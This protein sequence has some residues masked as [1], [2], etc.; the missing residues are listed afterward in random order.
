MKASLPF[1][2]LERLEALRK[3]Q[4][5]DTADELVYDDLV[6]LAASICSTPLAAISLLDESRMWFKARR[7]LDFREADRDLSFCAHAIL[8]P[9]QVLVVPDATTDPRFSD[10][11]LVRGRTQFRFYSGAPLLNPEGLP[12][13]TLCVIDTRARPIT[14]AQVEA[15]RALSRQ[16]VAQLELRRT[17][18]VLRGQ[19][20]ELM[21]AREDAKAASKA[22]STFLANI[23]HE[24]R[25]PMNGV[26]GVTSL[27]SATPLSE[28]QRHYVNTIERSAEGLLNV[29]S[30]ILDFS[31]NET[32]SVAP[33][34]VPI[35]LP[36]FIEEIADM[37]RPMAIT[38]QLRFLAGVD[39]EIR[40]PLV[41]DPIRLHQVLA[42]L[43]GNA[44]KFTLQGSVEINV[45]LAGEGPNSQ[46]AR[47]QVRDTGIGVSKEQQSA[48]FDEFVQ[49][50]EGTQRRF[51]GAGLGLSICRQL[52]K[53][54]GTKIELKSEIGI[55]STFWFDLEMPFEIVEAP[56]VQSAAAPVEEARN[57]KPRVL[58][59]EDNE[60][61]SLVITSMLEHNGCDVVCVSDGDE[62]VSAVAAQTF[63][64]VFMDVQ[65]PRMDGVEATK[66]IRAMT[67]SCRSV[68]IIALTASVLRED[69][70]MCQMAGMDDFMSKPISERSIS[71]ALK[72]WIV[73]ADS[74]LWN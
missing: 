37:M 2:E 66:V 3:Y 34:L 45:S 40:R 12:L 70:I 17:K 63:D 8:R 56:S 51:G 15:L 18:L 59:A 61:N 22:K 21:R 32:S 1:N 24:I 69:A 10:N 46:V 36:A 71:E 30:N 26:V 43:V 55:G 72:R 41:G 65:M 7:G 28:R 4:I 62:A 6:M 52:A 13:G 29:L 44:L 60:V 33:K 5:L 42:N 27:L 14:P 20:D 74:P 9:D 39:E 35:D 16:V 31:K 38:K 54:M 73:R 11:D 64:L 23:S 25:T 58:V 68:P 67:G 50:D 48:I 19:V 47:F 49:V 53:S 57:R